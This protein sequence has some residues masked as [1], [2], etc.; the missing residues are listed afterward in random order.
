MGKNKQETREDVFKRLN[1]YYF[2]ETYYVSPEFKNTEEE[3]E[4]VKNNT[5]KAIITDKTK[6]AGYDF[7]IERRLSILEVNKPYTVKHM[8]VS[9]SSGTV[10][11]EEFPDKYF[12]TVAFEY[13]I[14]N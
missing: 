7:E 9:Q 13:Y 12:N 14:E 1:R 4:W 8:S 6:N 2:L 3:H 5:F 10:T 11:L